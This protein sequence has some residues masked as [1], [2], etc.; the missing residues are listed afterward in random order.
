[1]FFRLYVNQPAM[2]IVTVKCFI[3]AEIKLILHFM[4]KVFF[5]FKDLKVDTVQ[6]FW[7]SFHFIH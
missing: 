3:K 6:P 7:W 1:M 2:L 4:N 5:T